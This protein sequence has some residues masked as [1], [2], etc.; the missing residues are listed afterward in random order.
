[1]TPNWTANISQ[2]EESLK[3]ETEDPSKLEHNYDKFKVYHK[4]L[5]NEYNKLK[6]KYR[7]MKQEYK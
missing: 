2:F 4:T 1:M 3:G 5:V 7:K 6:D